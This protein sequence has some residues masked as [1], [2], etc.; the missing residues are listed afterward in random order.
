MTTRRSTSSIL[1]FFG[2]ATLIAGAAA[3]IDAGCLTDPDHCTILLSRNTP[4]GT[5]GFLSAPVS[6]RGGSS[7]NFDVASTNGADTSSVNW[8]A[9][10]KDPGLAA[11]ISYLNTASLRKSPSGLNVFTGTATLIGGTVTVTGVPL[12]A[13]AIVL[14]MAHNPLGAPGKLSA[15]VASI[16]AT[17]GQFVINSSSG[18]DTSTVDWVVIDQPLRFSPSGRVFSQSSGNL[19]GVTP[20]AFANMNP[21]EESVAV[22]ASVITSA[23]TPG[24]MFCQTR[25]G[26]SIFLTDTAAETSLVEVAAF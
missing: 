16:N 17:T 5:L 4:S 6:G 25:S 10:P 2:T 24:N 1:A 12:G 19:T 11:S 7:T 21:L 22:I 26:G 3:D 14:C 20:V 23:G 15:P 13:A 18:S 8:V 9:I